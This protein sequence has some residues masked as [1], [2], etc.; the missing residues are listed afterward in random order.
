LPDSGLRTDKCWRACVNR[1]ASERARGWSGYCPAGRY[2]S[3]EAVGERHKLRDQALVLGI[4]FDLGGTIGDFEGPE[5]PCRTLDRMGNPDAVGGFRR[6]QARPRL[7]DLASE[8][9]EQFALQRRIVE[10]GAP[11]VVA[12]D[13]RCCRGIRCGHLG[14]LPSLTAF[15]STEASISPHPEALL[16]DC[17][18]KIILQMPSVVNPMFKLLG[19]RENA[20]SNRQSVKLP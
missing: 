8:H 17:S 2:C 1:A 16:Y 10:R 18:P 5:T 20:C 13:R 12:V 11:E 3:V 4:S 9:A 6:A 14:A 19:M 7:G 15:E